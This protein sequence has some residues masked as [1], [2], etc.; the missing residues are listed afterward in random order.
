MP[1]T[2]SSTQFGIGHYKSY[3]QEEIPLNIIEANRIFYILRNIS[4]LV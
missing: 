3:I 4:F 1:I 2:A